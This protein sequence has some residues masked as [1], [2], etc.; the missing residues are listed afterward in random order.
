MTCRV[1]RSRCRTPAACIAE[2][3][4]QTSMPMSA[5]SRALNR[6]TWPSAVSS[7]SPS[8]ISSHTPTRPSTPLGAVDGGE[9]G[10]RAPWPADARLAQ[11]VAACRVGP[12]VRSDR[13]DHLAARVRDPTPG[14]PGRAAPGPRSRRSV[15]CPHDSPGWMPD[16]SWAIEATR[17]RQG[18][19]ETFQV[20]GS[21]NLGAAELLQVR[22]H[23]LR[24]EQHEA[25]RPQS[26]H[27]RDER[28]LRGVG[29][30]CGTSTRRRRRRRSRRRR[31][32]R[33][34]TPSCQVSTECAKPSRCSAT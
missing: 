7:V 31:A 22:R 24:V 3:A 23:P 8:T 19:R 14:R 15:R 29:R 1:V 27:Q 25:A 33:R 4:S 18:C 17:E 2:R 28:D 34:A 21:T 6:P 12:D 13:Q 26:L 32:R 10:M 11:H 9:V 30:A 16:D 20:V 5:A